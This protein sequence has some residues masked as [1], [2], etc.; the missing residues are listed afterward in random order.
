MFWELGPP[1]EGPGGYLERLLGIILEDTGSKILFFSAILGVVVA[2][3][4]QDG[5]PEHQDDARDQPVEDRWELLGRNEPAV[6]PVHSRR[7]GVLRSGEALRL[8]QP[9]Q[10]SDGRGSS[11]GDE[12]VTLRG[13]GRRHHP[14]GQQ[15][16]LLVEIL[17]QELN[18]HPR[19]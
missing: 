18:Y 17:H 10:W 9:V 1:P 6:E 11:R 15:Q 12:R 16:H 14:N 19:M 8:F 2:S 4:C 5:A 7:V 3:W 13:E